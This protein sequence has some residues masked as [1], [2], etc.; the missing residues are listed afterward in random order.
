MSLALGI[1][2]FSQSAVDT[3]GNKEKAIHTGLQPVPSCADT[4][5]R[6]TMLG[7]APTC[8]SILSS[9]IISFSS[10]S[11]ATSE[12]D[13]HRMKSHEETTQIVSCACGGWLVVLK[14]FTL[15]PATI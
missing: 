11:E 3:A 15:H 9:E 13:E 8:C 5:R 6:L 14:L 12:V 7:W 10:S 4:P 1:T 2:L